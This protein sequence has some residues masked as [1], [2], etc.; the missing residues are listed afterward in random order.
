VIYYCMATWKKCWCEN[1][2]PPE[3]RTRPV[4]YRMFHRL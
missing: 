2:N 3:L 4:L 1:K